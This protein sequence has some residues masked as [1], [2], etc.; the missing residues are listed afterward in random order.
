M[1]NS[2]PQPGTDIAATVPFSANLIPAPNVSE[3]IANL[4][5][6]GV[7]LP[8]HAARFHETITRFG[9]AQ[10]GPPH[11]NDVTSLDA[12]GLQ[13]LS[14][15]RAIHK[16]VAAQLHE[17]RLTVK[18]EFVMQTAALLAANAD[19]ILDQLRP[20]FDHAVTDIA[21]AAAGINAT[22]SGDAGIDDGTT[23]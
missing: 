23:W 6:H 2:H 11:F 17:E 7:K 1:G 19:A 21:A 18:Q 14:I 15:E 13:R 3:L 12:D 20:R 10:F 16:T 9:A 22:T 5:A 4:I 8:T